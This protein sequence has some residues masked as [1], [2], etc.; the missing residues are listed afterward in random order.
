MIFGDENIGN[1]DARTRAVA[2]YLKQQGFKKTEYSNPD[3]VPEVYI[4]PSTLDRVCVAVN[5]VVSPKPAYES[6][7]L[8]AKIKKD[9][10]ALIGYL[11]TYRFVYLINSFDKKPDRNLFESTFI[12][13]A[14]DKADL[15]EE[16][17]DQYISLANEIVISA[18][19]Q[20]RAEKLRSLIDQI[21][22]SNDIDKQ[23]FSISLVEAIDKM[24]SEF[25]Q[26]Q[27]RQQKLISDLK[28]KRADRINAQL[29]DKGSILNLVQCWKEEE[30]RK[31]IIQLGEMR[32]AK[33]KEE[34]DNLASMEDLRARILGVSVDEILN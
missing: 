6:K 11:R 8:S 32:K 7:T 17:V 26:S 31:K 28:G 27:T 13:H 30:T 34:I 3:D 25:H 19:I 33:L 2:D 15:T 20:L 24:Q 5:R 12:R 9:M 4:P 18:S 1:L 23:K 22:E 29:S 14:Y 16:E 10:L 21:S